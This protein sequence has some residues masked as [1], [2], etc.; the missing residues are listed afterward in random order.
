MKKVKIIL[1]CLLVSIFMISCSVVCTPT[2]ATKAL[3]QNLMFFHKVEVNLVKE[4][5][6]KCYYL[7]TVNA[8]EFKG[9]YYYVVQ[10]EDKKWKCTMIKK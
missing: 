7:Y 9:T 8:K 5:N 1:T 10:M 2:K 3:K 4:D 6:R